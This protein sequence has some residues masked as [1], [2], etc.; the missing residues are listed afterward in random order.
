MQ[1]KRVRKASLRCCL[2]NDECWINPK[3]K[4]IF[5]IGRSDDTLT[6][7]GERFSSGEIYLAIDQMSELED[8]LCVGQDRWDGE[9]RAVLFVKLKKGLSFT[10]ELKKKIEDTIIKEFSD[11]NLPEV[12]LEV[13]DIPYNLTNKRLESVVRKIVATNTVPEVNN[14]K[15]PDSLRHYLDIPQLMNYDS[16]A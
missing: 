8:Y 15:N 13:P 6:Q 1:D 16:T 2:K 9:S 4:G 12:I 5:V 10:E 11:Y 14:I 7:N 3:T